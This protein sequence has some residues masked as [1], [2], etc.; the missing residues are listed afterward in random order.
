MR[1]NKFDNIK[2][3]LIILVILGHVALCDNI[4]KV[5]SEIN[6]F[7][8]TFTMPLF[9]IISGIFVHE[10]SFKN[11]IKRCK[12]LVVY[13]FWYLV[14]YL[15]FL[16]N[17]NDFSF[18]PFVEGYTKAIIVGNWHS[19]YSS[20]LWFIP[21][22][23]TL[24]ILVMIYKKNRLYGIIPAL[25]SIFV[26]FNINILR[27]Y[28]KF[29]PF[30]IDAALYMFIISVIFIELCRINFFN[31]QKLKA[32]YI[33]PLLII[34][35]FLL[36]K[37]CPLQIDYFNH[38]IDVSQ[39]VLP[40]GFSYI[41]FILFEFSIFYF[42]NKIKNLNSLVFLGKNTLLIFILNI[43]ILKIAYPHFLKIFS[44]DININIAYIIFTML[45]LIICIVIPLVIS[46]V[47]IKISNKTTIIGA[48]K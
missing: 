17:W 16:V 9:L 36:Y 34:T 18:G 26:I 21:A 10:I 3:I 8:Y 24:N 41:V 12:L 25:L 37:V 1:D 46:K 7:I 38:R 11:L 6:I 5:F 2:G 19:L 28:N 47:L 39:D 44:L 43:P 13:A 30:E 42:L 23:L 14:E 45:N 22:L 27:D 40:Q 35:T 4:S 48:R 32:Y 31:N 15:I 29:F 20:A 33:F